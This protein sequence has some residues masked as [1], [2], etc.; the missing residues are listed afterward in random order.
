MTCFQEAKKQ[1]C[2]G[3]GD[4][5]RGKVSTVQNH[6]ELSSDLQNSCAVRHS[7]GSLY[8][9]FVAETGQI[10]SLEV[11]GTPSLVYAAENNKNLCF[12]QGKL[13]TDT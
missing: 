6:E 10:G 4:D 2:L 3:C 12:K 1:A 5:S 13:S 11:Q 8:S 7:G 9:S